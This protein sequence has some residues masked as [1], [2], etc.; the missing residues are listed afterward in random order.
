M[1]P[2]GNPLAYGHET[3]EIRGPGPSNPNLAFRTGNKITQKNFKA[4]KF[5]MHG[6]PT[7]SGPYANLQLKTSPMR[8]L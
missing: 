1:F 4:L 2:G 3:V 6:F 8:N 7:L 5:N